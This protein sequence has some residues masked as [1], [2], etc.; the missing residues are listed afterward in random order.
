MSEVAVEIARAREALHAGKHEE[1]NEIMSGLCAATPQDGELRRLAGVVA[2]EA[3][4]HQAAAD[5]FAEAERL[6]NAGPSLDFD[7]GKLAWAQRDLEGAR[8]WFSRA[9]EARPKD[10]R[11]WAMLG[12]AMLSLGSYPSSRAAL[13]KALQ[14]D[15]SLSAA[16]VNLAVCD[17]QEGKWQEARERLEAVLVS[18]VHQRLAYANLQTVWAQ[19]GCHE[20]ALTFLA[21]LARALPDS[22][23]PLM[24]RG[25]Y[26]QLLGRLD[27]GVEAIRAAMLVGDDFGELPGILGSLLIE[28][29][30]VHEGIASLQAG[31]KR[32][33]EDLR[34][35]RLLGSAYGLLGWSYRAQQIYDRI[36]EI[37]PEDEAGLLGRVNHHVTYGEFDEAE[38][39]IAKMLELNPDSTSARFQ[40]AAIA[41]ISGRLE[42]A[43]DILEGLV[44]EGRAV[45]DG[46]SS[47]LRL[48]TNDLDKLAK[49]VER[50]DAL[51]AHTPDASQHTLLFA[52]GKAKGRLKDYAGSFAMYER[53]NALKREQYRPRATERA[54]ANL[55]RVFTTEALDITAPAAQG[56]HAVFIVGM[57]RSGTSLTEQIL[58][59]H[60]RIAA[61]GELSILPSIAALL[62]GVLRTG[63]VYPEF[64][65]DLD[66]EALTD[67]GLEY[68]DNLAEAVEGKPYATDKLPHNFLNVGF[69]RKI[70]PGAKIIHCRRNPMD[71]CMSILGTNFFGDH[72][73]AYSQDAL[74]HYYKL[75][76]GLM[77]HWRRIGVQMHEVRYEDMVSDLEGTM[78]GTL[79]YLGLE[80]E[81]QM[82]DFHRSERIVHTASNQQVRQPLY[83]SSVERWRRY[84][85]QLQ[86]LHAIL[87]EATDAYMAE[88][89]GER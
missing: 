53:G 34:L 25:H 10:A 51:A 58:G 62:P 33:P 80:W 88:L 64:V 50:A 69:I 12:G 83:T 38:V 22:P 72:P 60:S 57:P 55:E 26:F 32:D 73:Y 36:L 63:Q 3:G 78:R 44:D 7:R 87:G 76:L 24:Y 46:L 65:P 35:L 45:V 66:V 74:G 67:I 68:L 40:R 43:F 23:L 37:A 77:E 28:S 31:L 16:A 61:G 54:F 42:D 71:I 27:E 9:V 86:P 14:L 75:Y 89:R 70:M 85:A 56:E 11:A 5:H 13:R 17:Q 1:A 79:G 21:D 4:Q 30:R 48:E 6:G 82:A 39:L 49:V 19:L 18:D 47:M 15:P 8:Q 81:P 59:T 84:E 52:L 20:E 29:G 41:E 2:T